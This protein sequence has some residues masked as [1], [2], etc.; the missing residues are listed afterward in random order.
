MD[1]S[2]SSRQ[3]SRSSLSQAAQ[4]QHISGC[5]ERSRAGQVSLHPITP[6]R[7]R[8]IALLSR[9]LALAAAALTMLT[10]AACAT[11]P[12][13]TAFDRPATHAL[14]ATAD[15][16]LRTALLPKEATYPDES[17]VRLLPTGTE[18]LQARIALARAEADARRT[19]PGKWPL[20]AG[21]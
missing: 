4:G 19:H 7:T 14:S 8:R 1:V 2:E 9:G 5:T 3:L 20:S 11:R 16:S 15:T 12:P 21:A 18:A 10:L 17:G 13:A 6:A